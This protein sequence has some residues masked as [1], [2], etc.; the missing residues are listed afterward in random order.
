MKTKHQR[1]CISDVV[2]L[3]RCPAQMWYS[4]AVVQLRCGPAQSLSSSDD[5][6]Q[7]RV[8]YFSSKET[9]EQAFVMD[10]VP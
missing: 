8:S 6:V 7:L 4:S 3:R 2:R 9:I 1:W 10:F 5:V